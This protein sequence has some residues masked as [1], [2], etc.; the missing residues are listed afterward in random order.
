MEENT[1][2]TPVQFHFCCSVSALREAIDWLW[3]IY[4]QVSIKFK[5]G[6]QGNTDF[7]GKLQLAVEKDGSSQKETFLV[8]K[9]AAEHTK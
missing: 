7:M 4:D 2:S 9:L 6:N 5:S 8:T 3:L 1:A